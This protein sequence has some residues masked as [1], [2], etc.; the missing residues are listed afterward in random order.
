MNY[1]IIFNEDYIITSMISKLAKK[2]KYINKFILIHLM[3]S[4][5][6]SNNFIQNNEFYLSN[7]F[8]I[9]N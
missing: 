8:F 9:N 2:Y 3:H 4:K 5:S 6:I 1:K 7:Y